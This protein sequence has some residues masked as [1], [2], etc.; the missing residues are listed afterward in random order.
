MDVTG[1]PGKLSLFCSLPLHLS[2]SIIIG[3]G[4]HLPIIGTGSTTLSPSSLSLRDV[5]V[6]P[7]I[8]K[9]LIFVRKISCDNNVE[10]FLTLL[11]SL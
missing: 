3:N 2:S 5:V 6:A 11:V 1:H 10:V 8:V 9:D 4:H 7:G